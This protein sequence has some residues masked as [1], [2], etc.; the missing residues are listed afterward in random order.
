MVRAPLAP[1]TS[2]RVGS[3]PESSARRRAGAVRRIDPGEFVAAA[4]AVLL[5]AVMFVLAWYGIDRPPGKIDGAER[6]TTENAWHGL[7]LVRWLML[8]TIA[9]AIGSLILHLTQRRH[10]ASTDTSGT[11]TVLGMVTS[12]VLI[13]RVLIGLP[14]SASVVD[15]KLGALLGLLCAF[16]I[17]LGGYHSLREARTGYGR[18]RGADG[19]T[20]D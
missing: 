2:T 7:T 15:Q 18:S 5:L 4:S 17:A 20:D 8:L 12:I 9:V 14:Q 10:G 1:A 13:Y 3:E 11:V 19:E 16:G 6:V